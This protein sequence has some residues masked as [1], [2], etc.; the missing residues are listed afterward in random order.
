[1]TVNFNQ[2]KT[3]EWQYESYERGETSRRYHTILH[4]LK[5]VNLKV[6]Y[7]P[8][9]ACIFKDTKHT[10]MTS[11]HMAVL[12][13]VTSRFVHLFFNFTLLFLLSLLVFLFSLLTLLFCI[14][15]SVLLVLLAL[16]LLLVVFLGLFPILCPRLLSTT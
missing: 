9:H 7:D 16:F 13:S 15:F 6:V 2:C 10:I 12:P 11:T 3:K 8:G 14:T 4:M 5:I 1:M